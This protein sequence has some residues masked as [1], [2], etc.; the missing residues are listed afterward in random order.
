MRSRL[1]ALIL[2][3]PLPATASTLCDDLAAAIRAGRGDTLREIAKSSDGRIR[4]TQQA[5]TIPD[6]YK[7]ADFIGPEMYVLGGS[8]AVM[9]V[10]TQGT[11]HCQSFAFF[12]SRN[13]KTRHIDGPKTLDD[14]G[15]AYCWGS[16]IDAAEFNGVPT[17]VAEIDGE[18][19]LSMEVTARRGHAWDKTCKLEATFKP[20]LV[21]DEAY[22][23][24]K[25]L[26]AEALALA[27]QYRRDPK[28]NAVP[29]TEAER[30]LMRLGEALP[31]PRDMPTF[32]KLTTN[33]Y[34][35]FD[36]ETLWPVKANGETLLAM[37]GAGT[38]GWRSY[39]GNLVAFW[40]DDNGRLAPVASYQIALKNGAL[41]TMKVTTLP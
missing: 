15:D 13:G 8:G 12:D 16:Y 36:G 3:L 33:P 17:I 7:V 27:E 26:E 14:S 2:T 29:V 20:R 9:V 10:D 18:N 35:G 41:K 37:V 25:A 21:V 34:T 32:D 38:F 24:G 23:D 19:R 28:R 11:M 4:L 39:Q 5:A 31:S 30:S 40:R 6:R 22:G 1:L